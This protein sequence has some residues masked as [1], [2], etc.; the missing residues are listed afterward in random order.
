MELLEPAAVAARA[1]ETGANHAFNLAFLVRRSGQD[2]FTKRVGEL[3]EQ[4]N[5]RIDVRY[6]GPLPPYSFAHTEAPVGGSS[7]A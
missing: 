1:E 3:L 6:V 4:T 5:D 2:D 7:W